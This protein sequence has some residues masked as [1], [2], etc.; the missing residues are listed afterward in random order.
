MALTT[1]V[2]RKNQTNSRLLLLP[3]ELRTQIFEY[4]LESQTWKI[5]FDL[6]FGKTSNQSRHVNALSLLA[7]YRQIHAETQLLPFRLGLFSAL[8]CVSLHRWLLTI[9]TFQCAAITNI[10]IVCDF[11]C[12]EECCLDGAIFAQQWCFSQLDS[13]KR[14][15][16]IAQVVNV[17]T[18]GKSPLTNDSEPPALP[19]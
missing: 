3:P 1:S 10:Q 17:Q 14:I 5:G 6:R 2:T 7:T 18:V 15:Q 19:F 12:T 9:E 8:N 4:V 16:I 11:E 13:L